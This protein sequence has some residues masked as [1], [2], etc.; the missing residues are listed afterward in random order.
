MKNSEEGTLELRGG[1]DQRKHQGHRRRRQA[2]VEGDRV[3]QSPVVRAIG[4][5]P[6]TNQTGMN[7]AGNPVTGIGMDM[8]LRAAEKGK[9]V[10]EGKGRRTVGKLGPSQEGRETK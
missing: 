7:E 8:V 4:N 2:G 6:G 10:E 3:R 5:K 1:R 9:K